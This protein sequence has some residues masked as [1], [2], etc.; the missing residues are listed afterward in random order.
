MRRAPWA[1]LSRLPSFHKRSVGGSGCILRIFDVVTCPA[2]S[3]S[4]EIYVSHVRDVVFS[5]N[6]VGL[7]AYGRRMSCMQ[8]SEEA[9]RSRCGRCGS[10]FIYHIRYSAPVECEETLTQHP[11]NERVV[12]ETDCRYCRTN[13]KSAVTQGDFY[14]IQGNS[15]DST[16]ITIPE[17]RMGAKGSSPSESIER[18][19]NSDQ[20]QAVDI[21]PMTHLENTTWE[22]KKLFVIRIGIPTAPLGM[23]QRGPPLR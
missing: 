15:H 9:A 4:V 19:S 7:N 17:F 5:G 1:G 22:R 3:A 14:E 16:L 23:L 2:E 10:V 6:Y 8:G 12:P 20:V 18:P 11:E 21:S 13:E